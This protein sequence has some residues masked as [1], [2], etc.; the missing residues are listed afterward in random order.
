M[1]IEAERAARFLE[2][3]ADGFWRALERLTPVAAAV[4]AQL[5]F[6]RVW[7]ACA[8]VDVADAARAG[9]VSRDR[10][11]P[12]ERLRRPINDRSVSISRRARRVFGLGQHLPVAAAAPFVAR[13]IDALGWPKRQIIRSFSSTF[14]H[15][16]ERAATE[17]AGRG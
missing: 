6:P 5:E 3:P 8:L 12:Y 7:D 1:P 10:L 9:D 2:Q 14:V 11:L 4:R 17:P 13:T 15:P 16:R